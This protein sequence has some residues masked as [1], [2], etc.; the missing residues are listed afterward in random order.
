[1]KKQARKSD[2]IENE[3]N[4]KTRS[5]PNPKKQISGKSKKGMFVGIGLHKK[6]R[7]VVIMDSDGKILH[8]D[9]VENHHQ[10]TSNI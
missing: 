6:F 7:Q 9:R 5:L 4:S 1:M 8:N 10:S 2:S 3:P